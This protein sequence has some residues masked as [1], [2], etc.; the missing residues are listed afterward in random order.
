[1]DQSIFAKEEGGKM[2]EFVVGRKQRV[3]RSGGWASH[4]GNMA[5][6][7]TLFLPCSSSWAGS[8]ECSQD[9]VATKQASSADGVSAKEYRKV[10]TGAVAFL[11]TAQGEDGSFSKQNGLGVTALVVASL[12]GVGVP[13]DDPMLQKGIQFLLAYRQPDGGLY[14]PESKHTNYESCI[15]MLAFSKVNQAH[16]Y[17][18]LLAGAEAYVKKLQ[19][20]ESEEL[21]KED[22]SYGGAGYGSKSRPDLSNTS[23]LIDALKSVGRDENDEAIQR[24]LLFVSRCQNLESP[25]NTT[26]FASFSNDGGFYY[27]PA[28]GGESQAG[29]LPNGGLRSYASMTY[30]GLKSMV[31]AGVKKEDPRVQASL[32]FLKSNYSLDTNPGMGSSGLYYYYHTMAKALDAYGEERFEAEDGSHV[33]RAEMFAKLKAEQLGNGAWVNGD[34]RWLEGDPNLVTGYALLALSFLK[35]GQ[36]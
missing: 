8:S 16:Q 28:A 6:M 25:A 7:T 3:M 11:R 34:P 5:L 19:W 35:P 13:A 9:P 29:R 1:M 22:L 15:V 17:D 26:P 12:A 23:F 10:V 14:N 21:K 2:V 32:K 24:A 33:W 20:D 18:D 30:A 36:P 4:I 27:T 31:F